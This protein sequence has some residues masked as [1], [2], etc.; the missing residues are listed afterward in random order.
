MSFFDKNRARL[1]EDVSSDRLPVE[2]EGLT[3]KRLRNAKSIPLEQIEADS[4]HREHFEE[5]ALQRLAHSLVTEGQMQPIRVRYDALRGKYI[6]IA[7]ERRLRAARIAQLATLDCVVEE[8]AL[9]ESE[10]LRQQIIENALREDLKPTEQGRAFQAAMELDGL[11]GKE[12]AARLNVH[13][14]TVSRALGLLELPAEIQS[15]VDAGELAI[16]KAL[17]VKGD[18]EEA[19]KVASG[20]ASRR[21]TKEKKLRTS[22]GITVTLTARKNLQ[23][24]EMVLALEELLSSL[25]QSSQAA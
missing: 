6:V 4:Q 23:E 1:A 10:I 16:T 22:V 19:L 3:G 5:D 15:K 18:G 7:G 20:T 9:T 25:K 14:S 12:L 8:R 2:N 11:N 21:P 24:H 13:P 17:K